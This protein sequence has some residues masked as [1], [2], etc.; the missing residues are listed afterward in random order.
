M[1]G[2]G[3]EAPKNT[4]GRPSSPVSAGVN[5]IDEHTSIKGNI[6]AGGDIRIDG[7]LE[8]DLVCK[9]KLIIG[10]RGH[11][12]GDVDCQN[13]MIEGTFSGTIIVRDLLTLKDTA[14]VKGTIRASK[15]AVGSGCL[16]DGQ[17]TVTGDKDPAAGYSKPDTTSNGTMNG[18]KNQEKH[19]SNGAAVKA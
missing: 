18:V 17:C 16:I 11:I 15:M 9:A 19:K 10:E 2:N 3:K 13:A 1:F 12:T 5:T 6:Q 7:K 4:P 8:G 14:R